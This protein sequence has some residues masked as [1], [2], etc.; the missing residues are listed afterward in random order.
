MGNC[1]TTFS[2]AD[3]QDKS[4]LKSND[5]EQFHIFRGDWPGRVWESMDD[6]R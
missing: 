4:F 1:K 2:G 5:K 3:K 6:P